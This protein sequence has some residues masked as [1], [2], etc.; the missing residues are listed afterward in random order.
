MKIEDARDGA[1]LYNHLLQVL[2]LYHYTAKDIKFAG[3]KEN[4]RITINEVQPK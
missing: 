4:F 2:K 3:T 1:R